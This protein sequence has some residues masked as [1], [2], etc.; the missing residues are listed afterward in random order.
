MGL[1]LGDKPVILERVGPLWGPL[2]PVDAAP[3]QG[4]V[5]R[6]GVDG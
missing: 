2:P 1:W 5:G 6:S 3:A 4:G